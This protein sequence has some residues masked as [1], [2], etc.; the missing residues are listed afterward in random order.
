MVWVKI[1]EDDKELTWINTPS[2][3][4]KKEKQEEI[5]RFAKIAAEGINWDRVFKK[6]Y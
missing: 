3:Q 5:K 6:K 2:R 1:N 4:T